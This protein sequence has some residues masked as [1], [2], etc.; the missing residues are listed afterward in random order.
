[1]K[2]TVKEEFL[3]RM[4]QLLKEEYE[5]FLKE[6]DK[7][8]QKGLRVNT[9]KIGVEE[10]KKIVPFEITPIPWCPTGFYYDKEE[11]A[12][13]H[14]YHILGLYYIQEPTAM[15]VVEVLDPKPGEKILDVSAAPGGK[16]THIATKIG[17]KGIIVANEIDNKRIKALVENIER[18]GIR[19]IVITNESPEKLASAFKGYFD[20]ILVDAPC[21]G[22]G[23]FRKDPTARKIWSLN[24]VMSC[25]IIQ[26]NILRNVAP[27]LKPGGILVYSTCTF[28]PEEN[29][30]VIKK[31]LEEHLEFEVEESEVCK[32]F[33]KGHPEWVEG[34]EDLSKCIRLWPHKLKGEG[35]FIAKLRKK[36]S[37]N[38]DYKFTKRKNSNNKKGLELFYDFANKYL[39]LDLGVLNLEIYNNFVYHVSEDLPYLG[40]IKVYRY[41]WQLGELKKNRFEPS[42]WLAMGIK[43]H[44][45]Q[46]HLE[47]TKEYKEKYFN[48]ETFELDMEDG[49]IFF[50][51]EGLGAVLM[52]GPVKL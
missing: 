4:E 9:L 31:F 32:Y 13:N 26:K 51:A 43:T 18:M 36:D 19:N 2:I 30:G 49:W 10:F 3:K 50:T 8:S 40:N 11:K 42:H 6:Y 41:G 27:L 22:E 29:E 17:D 48:G 16:T 38:E 35:H 7:K 23:M 46:R 12:G 52:R 34:P 5:D 44:E 25:S 37:D 45:A 24:N 28:S 33:D 15:A 20:K 14:L 39:N 21:S 47:L 1:M